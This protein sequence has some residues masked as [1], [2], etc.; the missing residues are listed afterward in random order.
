[1]KLFMYELQKMMNFNSIINEIFLNEIKAMETLF[2][3]PKRKIDQKND[4]FSN[5]ILRFLQSFFQ[6]LLSIKKLIRYDTIIFKLF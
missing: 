4:E 3:N 2:F 6:Q 1:M 5:T